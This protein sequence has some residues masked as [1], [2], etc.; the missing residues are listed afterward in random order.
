MLPAIIKKAIRRR[1]CKATP[2]L[3]SLATVLL[4][5]YCQAPP[6]SFFPYELIMARTRNRFPI[7]ERMLRCQKKQCASLEELAASV[8]TQSELATSAI[9]QQQEQTKALAQLLKYAQAGE[10]SP[11]SGM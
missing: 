8:R 1:Q 7:Y 3:R 2:F 4:K 11:T 6:T 10:L 5:S 9:S